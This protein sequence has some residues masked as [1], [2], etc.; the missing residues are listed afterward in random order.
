MA[1]AA[2]CILL[3]V[4]LA[5]SSSS[6]SSSSHAIP[7]ISHHC[8]SSSSPWLM[9]HSLSGTPL[10]FT[11]CKRRGMAVAMAAVTLPVLTFEGEKVGETELDLKAARAETAKA[12]V[13][14]GVITELQNKRRGTASTLT[15]GEVRGGGRKPYKQK[16][17][18]NARR[19]SQR[20]PLR[21]GGGII[22]GPKPK[23]WSI[24]INKKEKRLAI[25]TALQSAAVNT[26][27]VED[28][29]ERFEVPR[30]KDFISALKR[31]GIQAEEHSLIFTTNPSKN[32]VLSSRNVGTVK[33][34]TPRSL[35]L[36]DVLR[37]DKLVFTKSAVEY[38][39]RMYGLSADLEDIDEVDEQ[40]TDAD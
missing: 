10:T 16:G 29:E 21:P 14:R 7:S 38:L 37:A 6:A 11:P 3:P 2:S 23:D 12:V 40:L 32:F 17:T 33:L 36:Y 26:V 34:I 4:S 27:V 8:S 35:N 31:W 5:S 20:T 30:T 18:G 39:N 15:R 22:F 24:K 1:M 28:F 9:R 25:S 13:H 19:G